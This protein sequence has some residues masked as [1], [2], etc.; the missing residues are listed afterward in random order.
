MDP[1]KGVDEFSQYFDRTR[2]SKDVPL[3]ADI[4]AD[5]PPEIRPDLVFASQLSRVDFSRNS[6]VRQVLRDRLVKKA[7]S[8]QKRQLFQLSRRALAVTGTLIL[9][10]VL[11]F[12]LD[13]AIRSA[14]PRVG[15][16]L[17]PGGSGLSSGSTITAGADPTAIP[18]PLPPSPTPIARRILGLESTH[19]DLRGWIIQPVWDTLWVEGEIHTHPADGTEMII[20][21]Q[22]WLS[23]D[24]RGRVITSKPVPAPTGFNLDLAPARVSLS[25]GTTVIDYDVDTKQTTSLATGPTHPLEKAN[26]LTEMLFPS[27]LAIRNADVAPIREEALNGRPALVLD[28]G[29]DRLWVDE[30]TGLL[31][32]QEHPGAAGDSQY[33]A[34]QVQ[35]RQI[36]LGVAL[37]DAIIH[38]SYPDEL[39]F[40]TAPEVNRTP[41][42]QATT[43]IP[44]QAFLGELVY[45]QIAG[46][47]PY[48]RRMASF[49]AECLL[50]QAACPDPTFLEG[51]PD[52]GV[53]ELIWSPDHSLAVFSDTNDNKLIVFDPVRR[54]WLRVLDGFFQSHLAWSA[55][56]Q[57]LAAV[58][59]SGEPYNDSLVVIDKAGWTARTV[60]TSLKGNKQVVGWVGPQTLAVIMT[61]GGLKGATPVWLSENPQPGLYLV[62]TTTGKATLVI[63]GNGLGWAALSPEGGMIAYVHLEGDQSVLMLANS[64]GSNAHALGKTGELPSW[65][66]D[67][68][69]I[70]FEKLAN[71]GDTLALIHP[72]GSGYHEV[73]FSLRLM[74]SPLW[75]PDGKRILVQSGALTGQGDPSETDLVNVEDGALQKVLM[76]YLQTAGIWKLLGWEPAE[77]LR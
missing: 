13:L 63:S 61:L 71:S 65:S 5:I 14:R 36:V 39:R 6:R 23:H 45:L 60:A 50:R 73:H 22:A 43:A 49:P 46:Q 62:E 19:A 1:E 77:T 75:S 58:G 30:Q 64:D 11:A 27:F 76:P 44:T 40:E 57:S 53:D 18:S 9:M 35:V 15:S 67:R 38:P 29:G 74:S 8:N 56:G 55:D 59:D 70:L 47:P 24:G 68:Q 33:P 21:S 51:A 69:W 3:H 12:S 31:L 32:R 25:D 4:P 42:P 2:A 28:W 54:Q 10:V 26:L 20:Y 17:L 48:Q 16:N 41:A 72:D 52:V 7:H 34:Y 66:P 37:T